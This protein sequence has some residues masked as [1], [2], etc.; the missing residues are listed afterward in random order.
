[1]RFAK[2]LHSLIM[3]VENGPKDGAVAKMEDIELEDV[4]YSDASDADSNRNDEE[5]PGGVDLGEQSA[6]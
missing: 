5:I 2:S 4:N 3:V 6:N 1:M